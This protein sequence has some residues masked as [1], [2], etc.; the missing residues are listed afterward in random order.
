MSTEIIT[1]RVSKAEKADI[2]KAAQKENRTLSNY[3]RTLIVKKL[4]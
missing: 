2:V 1:I 4:K 3:L